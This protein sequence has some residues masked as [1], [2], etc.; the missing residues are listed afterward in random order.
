MLQ[1]AQIQFPVGHGGL[2]LTQLF[3]T[4]IVYQPVNVLYD[5]GTTSRKEILESCLSVLAPCTFCCTEQKAR[6]DLFVLSHLHE[7]HI[8]GFEIIHRKIRPTINRLV[9]PHYDDQDKL[10][11]L[12]Q[13]AHSGATRSKLLRL[14]E[15]LSD[16][17]AWFRARGV[18]QILAVAPGG[19][20]AEPPL[21]AVP[22]LPDEGPPEGYRIVD[23]PEPTPER[24][25]TEC[26][27]PRRGQTAR[28]SDGSYVKLPPGSALR[29][30][31]PVPGTRMG[32]PFVVIPYCLR[33]VPGRGGHR[34]QRRLVKEVRS[35]LEPYRG[36]ASLIIAPNECRIVLQRL[37]DAF[38]GYVGKSDVVANRLSV[39]CYI[40][41]DREPPSAALPPFP[42]FAL[43]WMEYRRL[44]CGCPCC[45]CRTVQGILVLPGPTTVC[46]WLMTGDADLRRDHAW[47]KVFGKR[48]EFPIVL[49]APHHGADYSFP[50]R[51][52]RRTVCVFS[53]CRK[54]DRHHPGPAL[55]ASLMAKGIPMHRVT[56]LP[57][58]TL[59]SLRWI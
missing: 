3:A 46:G 35:I 57:W 42:P 36:G 1:L 58:T 4:N 20:T 19:P 13:A 43:H 5:C 27:V 9:I 25:G 39:I 50:T 21:P 11:V 18:R 38:A 8:N 26:Y 23:W 53:T 49:Q 15:V 22:P 31:S 33:S 30:L 41:T 45:V 32:V 44:L 2:H 10:V 24:P 34:K 40:G 59:A 17:E 37:K 28:D 6:I 54:R 47:K 48:L 51:I 12:A 16:P 55:T 52:P 7:D 56:T 29:I 14:H